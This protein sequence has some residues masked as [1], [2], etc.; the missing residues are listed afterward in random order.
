MS[1]G[2][3]QFLHRV[4]QSPF[5]E[6]F[7]L[8][9]AQV[10]TSGNIFS[11]SEYLAA[12]ALLLVVMV[13][14]DFR[15]R[16]RLSL[17]RIDLR[18]VGFWV[19]LGVGAAILAIDVWF[20]NGFPIPKFMANPN[21]LKAVLGLVFLVIVFL[22]ISVAVIRPPVFNKTNARRFLDVNYHFIHHGNADRIQVIAEEL[23]RSIGAI[24][25][26]AT[27]LP[28]VR[29][30]HSAKRNP[31]EAAEAYNIL[32]LLADR[33][34][35]KIVVD[36][37][38]A[39][40]LAFLQ[41]LADPPTKGLPI[42]PFVRNIGQEFI[43]NKDSSLYQEQSI[44]FSGLLGME[45]PVTKLLFGSY[46]FIEA[47]ANQ[48]G[49]PLDIEYRTFVEF[50]EQ[51][52]DG[53]T[54]AAL[55]FLDSY[56]RATRGSYH[57]RA[58]I[59]LLHSYETSVARTYEMNGLETYRKTTAYI[60]LDAT[61]SFICEAM[62]L[63][64]KYAIKPKTFR[65]TDRA[66]NIFDRLANLVIETIFA[67]SNVSSPIWTAWL[68][69][70]NTVWSPL[71]NRQRSATHKIIALKVRRL[72][73][74][75]IKEMDQAVNFRGAGLL[76]FCLNVLGLKLT[77]RH[78]GFGREFY[79]LQAATLSWIKANYRTLLAEHPKVAEACLQGRISY[80]SDNHRLVQTYSDRTGKEPKREF[81]YLD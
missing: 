12:L 64:E 2:L 11:F 72:L 7:R 67:A 9:P 57:S 34:F 4:L 78:R 70:H 37:V 81:L 13:A 74:R 16:Y 62:S 35:C 24:V 3:S 52:M 68:I 59:R 29:D 51:Q 65:R 36:K 60:H 39:F 80:D 8:I 45:R 14:S 54:R 43:R 53:F 49:S 38:P 71:F 61:V 48:G 21:N 44:Y 46:E 22:A 1:D 26:S 15:S 50:D 31:P 79:P 77:D 32:L 28:V 27:K 55:S 69:Q 5:W 10:P 33:R 23:R 75:E 20:Q 58:F 56:L 17:A 40:A 41:E 73:Y 30:G 66:D 42:F 76:G 63:V 6:H 18:T 47:C 19:G 25:T